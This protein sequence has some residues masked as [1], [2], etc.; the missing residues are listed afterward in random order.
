MK[1]TKVPK[2]V[3]EKKMNKDKKAARSLQRDKKTVAWN[4][5]V[6]VVEDPPVK[7]EKEFEEEITQWKR[8]MKETLYPRPD[9][10]DKL[11]VAIQDLVL[12][13]IM[14]PHV[15]SDEGWESDGDDWFE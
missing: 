8:T 15:E 1:N 12:E 3:E 5:D 10:G 7:T 11:K 4:D 2:Y 6:I 9:A 13:D 14:P